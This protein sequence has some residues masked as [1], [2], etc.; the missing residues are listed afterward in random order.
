MALSG[1]FQRDVKLLVQQNMTEAALAAN[2]AEAAIRLRAEAISSGNAPDS[3]IRYVDGVRDR[4]ENAVRPDG[5]IL[6]H[7]NYLPEATIFAIQQALQKS[8]VKTGQYRRAWLVVVNGR[9]WSGDLGRIPP[10]SEVMVL[11]PEPYSRKLDTGAIRS[12][13]K[14]IIE[15][16]RRTVNRRFPTLTAQRKFMNIPAGMIPGAPWI[17]KRSQSRSRDRQAG[18]P[19]TYPALVITEKQ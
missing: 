4:P 1:T 9:I 19:V 14:G 13:A 7:F 6:Y 12:S 2:L 8:P 18:Q 15:A 16:V 17:L 3:W 5:T 10:G 11:N